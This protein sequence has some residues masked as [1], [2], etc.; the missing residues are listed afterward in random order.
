MKLK[1]VYLITTLLFLLVR[2]VLKKDN[3]RA[4]TFTKFA[5]LILA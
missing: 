5:G 4:V 2:C 3:L 1:T